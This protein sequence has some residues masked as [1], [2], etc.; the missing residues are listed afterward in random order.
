MGISVSLLRGHRA[1][2]RPRGATDG[3]LLGGSWVRRVC[4]GVANTQR[5][6]IAAFLARGVFESHFVNIQ[7]AEQAHGFSRLARRGLPLSVGRE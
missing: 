1:E 6:A 5:P 2:L 4:S 3:L 7:R